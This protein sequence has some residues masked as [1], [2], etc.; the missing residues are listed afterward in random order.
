MTITDTR[1]DVLARLPPIE[2]VRFDARDLDPCACPRIDLD[3]FVNA[4]WRSANPIPADRTAWDCFSILAERVRREEARIAAQAADARSSG[5][6]ERIVGD[7]WATAMD[8][9]AAAAGVAI[10]RAKLDRIAALRT[11]AEIAAYLCDRHACGSGLVFRF[12][13]APDFDDPRR[14]IAYILQGGLGLPDRSYYLDTS[15]EAVA[16]REAYVAHIAASLELAGFAP[17]SAA[18]VLVFETRLAEA[19]L[20][21]ETLARDIGARHRP[22]DL[23]TAERGSANFSWRRFFEAQG[24][25][26]PSRFSLAMPD[27]H[28]AV[29]ALLVSA[30]AS[31]WRAYLAFHTIDDAAPFLD[32]AF[33]AQHHAFHGRI[34]RGRNAIKPRWKRALDAIDAEI[35]EA[36]GRLYVE[37]AFPPESKRCVQRLVDRLRAAFKRRLEQLDWLSERGKRAAARKLTTLRAKIGYPDRWRD[38]SGLATSRHSLYANVLAARAH[39]HRWHLG[40]LA[41]PVDPDEWPIAPQTV[42]AGYDPQRNEIVFP[43]AILQP[44]FFDPAAD[45]ALN[46]GGIGAVVAHEITHGFDD[47]GSRFDENGRFVN[48]WTSADRACFD[49]RAARLAEQFDALAIGG[50]RVNGRLTLGENIAD[51]GGLAVAFDALVDELAAEGH[52]DPILDGYTQ[53]QRFF[54]NWAVI[55]R[56]KLTPD[57]AKLRRKT[58]PHAPAKIRAN[59]AAANLAAFAEAFACGPGD[60]MRPDQQSRIQIW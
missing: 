30:P 4:R 47:Q 50:E 1:R 17:A 28:A 22:I 9:E 49:A 25:A 18:D 12:D 44:P 40:R 58:D 31:A 24:V 34:L 5:P 7:F 42:N 59:A 23:E 36:M 21:R 35:G 41:R 46:Y 8:E 2:P 43:A 11:P 13:V 15:G 6:E 55:W 26:P 38:W 19:S 29:D 33:A 60:P 39:D 53:A 32:D 27:F 3:A 10:L 54:L 20:A 45:A 52:A 48:W 14:A 51:F 57:E 56:Q 16:R 37:R